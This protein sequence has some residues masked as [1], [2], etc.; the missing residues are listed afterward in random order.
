MLVPSGPTRPSCSHCISILAGEQRPGSLPPRLLLPAAP[1]QSSPPR[2]LTSA[3]VTPYRVSAPTPHPPPALMCS[4]LHK[5]AKIPH[6]GGAVVEI[7]YGENLQVARGC[8]WEERFYVTHPPP[9]RLKKKKK[10][11]E[12]GG[13]DPRREQ[14]K[15]RSPAKA[16]QRKAWPGIP[17]STN[18][19]KGIVPK[20]PAS[21]PS[22]E[23]LVPARARPR[24]QAAPLSPSARQVHP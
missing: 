22:R 8:H 11:R 14:Q 19:A 10:N 17:S 6:G 21:A 4:R 20:V 7:S 2:A 1:K 12:D 13:Q 5:I 15:W 9:C 3:L 18:L 16:R 24:P 23:T